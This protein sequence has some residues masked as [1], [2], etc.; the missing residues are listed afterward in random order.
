MKV[1]EKFISIN[2]E[3][4]RAGEL[5]VFVRFQGCNLR[6]SYCDTSWAYAADCP[7][8]ELTPDEI[9]EYVLSTGVYDV[10]LTGGEPLLAKGIAELI[11]KLLAQPKIRVE[12]ETNGAVDLRPFCTPARPVFTMDYKLPSS[13]WEGAMKVENFSVLEEQDTVKFVCGSREDLQRAWE[14]IQEYGL[15]E[16]CHVYLSPVFG[17]I[18]PVDMV[19]FME[20]H[21]MNDVRLQIQ[22]HKV[23]WDPEKRGV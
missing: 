8:E 12:I 15:T 1:A 22:I 17:S 18:E 9:V 19:A 2:G 10:T 21:K 14:V 16:R 23:I 5:S 7:Y 6:C 4:N 3:G 13:G 11:E 20:T